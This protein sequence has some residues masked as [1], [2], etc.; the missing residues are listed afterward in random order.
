MSLFDSLTVYR[1]ELDY[2]AEETAPLAA[3]HAQF[4]LENAIQTHTPSLW[5]KVSG[6]D[7]FRKYFLGRKYRFFIGSHEFIGVMLVIFVKEESGSIRS[8]FFTES[9]IEAKL[10]SPSQLSKLGMSSIK[11]TKA[12]RRKWETKFLGRINGA[13]ASAQCTI[14]SRTVFPLLETRLAELETF[15]GYT[16]NR[17]TTRFKVGVV[18]LDDSIEDEPSLFLANP[19][20]NRDYDEFLYYLGTIL[21]IESS[22]S[23]YTGGLTAQNCEYF[24]HHQDVDTPVPEIAFHVNS[25][26]KDPLAQTTDDRILAS[27]RHIANDSVVIVFKTGTKRFDPTLIRSQY[28][29]VYFVIEKQ[30]PDALERSHHVSF[31]LNDYLATPTNPAVTTAGTASAVDTDAQVP[32]PDPATDIFSSPTPTPSLSSSEAEKVADLIS[33]PSVHFASSTSSPSMSVEAAASGAPNDDRSLSQTTSETAA[34]KALQWDPITTK[35]Q[36]KIFR[37]FL[38]SKRF[39]TVA[40]HLPSSFGELRVA[41]THKCKGLGLDTSKFVICAQHKGV[42]IEPHCGYFSSWDIGSLIGHWEDPNYQLMFCPPSQPPD[43]YK[44]TL[45]RMAKSGHYGPAGIAQMYAVHTPCQQTRYRL[46]I[47]TK[48]GVSPW[49]PPFPPVTWFPA[50]H[51]F[52]TFLIEKLAGA[53]LSCHLSAQWSQRFARSRKLLLEELANAA[54]EEK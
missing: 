2:V 13:L 23:V 10:F 9:G 20:D 41:V 49:S 33:E 40:I 28:T 26:L 47:V 30:S 46:T 51:R 32:H 3:P 54:T 44:T 21:P 37:V 50:D 45:E 36:V 15:Q 48:E 27:K 34:F 25:W 4:Y 29:Q 31:R 42:G 24:L 6:F 14:S 53:Q 11:L 12:Q 17:T 35:K 22:N 38:D 18:Y 19:T 16:L 39:K 8:M 5:R 7:W 52:K 1:K 43:S